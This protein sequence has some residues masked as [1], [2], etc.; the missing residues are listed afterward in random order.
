MAYNYIKHRTDQY[1]SIVTKEV[2]NRWVVALYQK[3][4]SSNK[5]PD[6]VSISSYLLIVKLYKHRGGDSH[7]DINTKLSELV[8][9]K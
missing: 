8:C 4:S 6:C 5:Q 1:V 9:I 3:I 7:S 2:T